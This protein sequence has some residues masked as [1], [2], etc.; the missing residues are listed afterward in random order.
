MKV[1][2]TGGTGLIGAKL[3]RSLCAA[4]YTVRIVSRKNLFSQSLDG[5]QVEW[6]QADLLDP[7]CPFEQIVVGCSMVFN[8]AGE[9]HDEG[10]MRAL[11]F[12]A[13]NQLI[14]AVKYQAKV[15][16]QSLHWVQLS[17]VGAYGPSSSGAS[18]VRV[19]TEESSPAPVGTYEVTKTL[20]D[21]LV[22]AA[23]EE[24]VFSYSILRP[25]NVYGAGMPNNSIRQWGRMIKKKF[26]FYI[27]AP[28]AIST[29]VHVD[30]V[31]DALILCGFDERA[32][33][34][35]FNISNDCSLESV[36]S[37]MAKALSAPNPSLRL[38]EGV[39]RFIASLFSWFKRFP[40]SHSR[41][42][43]L[44]SR[45]HY[46]VNKLALVLGYRPTRDVEKTIAEVLFDEDGARK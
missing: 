7:A 33:G 5:G 34:Q 15:L 27:G 46:P 25:S 22:M 36:V 28:G 21:S 12:N 8:C 2:V 6:I 38:P 42:D 43:A 18:S 26:F 4:G 30:D 19:V 13:T 41:I 44:V 24:G 14:A 35:I 10:R 3:V 40:L 1:L 20:A 45:T 39:V 11:H 31:V 32:K 29:Y 17:S 23:A 16:K 37:A 9:L